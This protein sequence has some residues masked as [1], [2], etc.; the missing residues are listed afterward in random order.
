MTAAPTNMPRVFS[1]FIATAK[2][3]RRGVAG[4]KR[5]AATA[6]SHGRNGY[7]VRS[8]LDPKQGCYM[9]IILHQSD[10][11]SGIRARLCL[12]TVR[13]LAFPP[14]NSPYGPG[15]HDQRVFRQSLKLEALWMPPANRPKPIFSARIEFPGPTQ[16]YRIQERTSTCV[17]ILSWFTA[18]HD[19]TRGGRMTS[20][21]NPGLG[22]KTTVRM[23]H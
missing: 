21:T 1:S 12:R 11:A 17:E 10:A 7:V 6:V 23:H 19:F 16:R 4:R 2:P 8:W 22:W 18:I 9:M 20:D 5:R 3:V 14:P 15:C 13:P